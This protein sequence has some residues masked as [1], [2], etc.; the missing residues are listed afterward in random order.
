VKN[1]V[2]AAVSN[3]GRVDVLL[4]NAGLMPH[5][6]LERLKIEDWDRTI[7]GNIKGVLYGIA[8]ALPNTNLVAGAR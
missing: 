6:P 3:Y 8:A 2:D 5:S 7:D 4:N 1:L